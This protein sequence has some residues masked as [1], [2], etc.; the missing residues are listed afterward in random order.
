MLSVSRSRLFAKLF[1]KTHEW[2]E[3]VGK[4]ATVGLSAYAV[5]HL[6]DVMA[7]DIGTG[8]QIPKGE[9]LGD[10]ESTKATSP[11][12]APMEGSVVKVNPAVVDDP[13]L[14]NKSPEGDGWIVKMSLT[15]AD[16]IG[17]LMSEDRYKDFLSGQ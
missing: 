8:R 10:L 1:S 12:M 14:I 4:E 3:I 13:S 6:G 16:D 5:H 2:I 17:H 15:S 11:V 9:E 7:V